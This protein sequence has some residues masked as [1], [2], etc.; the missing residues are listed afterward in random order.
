MTPET[1]RQSRHVPKLVRVELRIWRCLMCA[2]AVLAAMGPCGTAW[3]AP[4]KGEQ[5]TYSSP[6]GLT[7]ACIRITHL[8]GGKYS[9]SDRLKEQGY[10][11]LDLNTLALCPKLWSTSPGTIIYEIDAA[12]YGGE[13]RAF[14]SKECG[15][16]HRAR[17]LAEGNPAT[18]KM[19]VNG[20]DTSATYAPS[21]WVYYHLSRYLDTQ[22]YVPVAVYRSTSRSIH[23]ERVVEPALTILSNRHGM[24]MLTAGWE[25][26]DELETGEKTGAAADALL[27]DGGRQVFG[28]LVHGQGERYDAEM[29]GTRESGWGDGQN[30]DFQQTAAYLA[31]RSGLPLLE[32]AQE[33]VREARKNPRM[34]K[35]LPQDTPLA[36]IVLWMGDLIEFTLLDYLLTQQDRIGNIDYNWRWYWVEDGALQSRAAQG[37]D[38]PGDISQYSPVRLK[39]S[40]I[41]DNDAGVRS[42]Y[43]NFA[44]RTHMLEGLRHYSPRLFERFKALAADL[45][46]EGEVYRWLTEDAGLSAR[47]A[48]SIAQRSA[49]A[50]ALLK[51]DRENGQLSLDI[52]LVTAL[53]VQ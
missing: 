27:T 16:G 29:N 17:Q 45:A 31:L 25:V 7:E 19:S 30:Y 38:V 39:Q 14:E 2:T 3:A 32:A 4:V 28:V 18:F 37:S 47:E 8:A 13:V 36:Q 42:G 46:A 11:A 24:K 33:G 44:A 26:L 15:D 21:S 9:E 52:D 50:Y 22:V 34:A 40:A 20:S 41:N 5:V 53:T 12:E 51:S 35:D 1:D 48:D 43:T 23:H 6:D 49:D 10:C